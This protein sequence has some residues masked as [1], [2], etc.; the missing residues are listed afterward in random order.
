MWQNGDRGQMSDK[1]KREVT[2]YTDGASSPNPGV[3]GWAAILIDEKT[4]RT[5]EISGSEF[6]STNNRM[7][8][9]SALE[10][11]SALKVPCRVRLISDSQ[12]L[13]HAFNKKWI[14]RWEIEKW[15][16]VKNDDLWRK[17]LELSRQHDIIWE[18]CRGHNG[19]HYNEKC[20]QL[21][22]NA[23]LECAKQNGTK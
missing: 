21:A 16:D 6:K 13:T 18:W 2:I 9:T 17:I 12:Y 8:L 5:K 10:G 20:D 19:N 1:P 14:Y 22:V 3:G 15:K 11:L 7:E 4:N 23:R